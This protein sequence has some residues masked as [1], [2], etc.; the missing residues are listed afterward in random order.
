MKKVFFLTALLVSKLAFVATVKKIECK[1]V[2]YDA[3]KQA[4]IEKAL[5]YDVVEGSGIAVNAA[6]YR[7]EVSSSAG[8]FKA[9][10]YIS[11]TSNSFTTVE[12]ADIS[13]LADGEEI[14]GISKFVHEPISGNVSVKYICKKVN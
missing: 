6:P 3:N 13:L 4:K 1:F 2:S 14:F 11:D 7:F 10:V 5:A 12:L 9:G 8:S